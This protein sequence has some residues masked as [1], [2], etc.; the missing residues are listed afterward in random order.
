MSK[1]ELLFGFSGRIGREQ[2]WL[3]LLIHFAVFNAVG[4][5]AGIA[6]GAT[7]IIPGDALII[8]YILATMLV[9]LVSAVAVAAKR[10]HDLGYSHWWLALF[11]VVMALLF[12]IEMALHL[13]PGSIASATMAL[14]AMGMFGIML[15]VLGAIRGIAGPNEYGPD[16]LAMP[17]SHGRP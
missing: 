6:V 14:S 2:F 15:I 12:G 1:R 7:G 11:A 16:P 9:L 13:E 3:A 10:L 8:G 5:V 4:I 17:L